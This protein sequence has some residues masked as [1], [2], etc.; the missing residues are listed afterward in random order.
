[1]SVE[2]A[3]RAQ[4]MMTKH[5]RRATEISGLARQANLCVNFGGGAAQLGRSP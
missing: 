5:R 3:S 2:I 4:R 1:M